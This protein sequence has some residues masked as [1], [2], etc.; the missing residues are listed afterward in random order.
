MTTPENIRAWFLT[1]PAISSIGS[2]NTDYLSEDNTEC[3]IYSM[4]SYL[5]YKEDILG[6]IRYNKRQNL[7]FIFA[8]R[9]P[10]G[11]DAE[12]NMENLELMN[13]IEEWMYQQNI[14]GNLPT[15]Q[16][17]TVISI[18]PTKTPA[19]ISGNSNSAVY[20]IQCSLAYDRS[21]E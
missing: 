10:F 5:T 8:I 1:C 13:S 6:K 12:K 9:L 19:P 18:T 17:G 4:P 20:Q 14:L 11:D 21:E 16:E 7:S 15:I 2:F 3:T